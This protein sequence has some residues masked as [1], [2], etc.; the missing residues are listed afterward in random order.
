MAHRKKTEVIIPAVILP[1]LIINMLVCT[2]RVID[3][4]EFVIGL[5]ILVVFT[6]GGIT[7]YLEEKSEAKEKH[8]VA[9]SILDYGSI[10][11]VAVVATGALFLGVFL[12]DLVNHRSVEILEGLVGILNLVVGL[13]MMWFAYRKLPPQ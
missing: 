11:S 8:A 6:F 7:A 4:L 9:P 5:M 1:T 3:R 10:L 12:T 13:P 2:I